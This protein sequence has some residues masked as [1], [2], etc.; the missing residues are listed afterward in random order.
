MPKPYDH[1]E[2]LHSGWLAGGEGRFYYQTGTLME[3]LGFNDPLEVENAIDRALKACRSLNISID[4]N[5]KKVYCYNGKEVV[6]EWSLSPLA[7]CLVIINSNPDNIKV[8]EA[9]LYFLT[10]SL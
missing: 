2:N 3:K 7:C 4:H 9:Q 1:F 5:F 6:T 8:A 10:G